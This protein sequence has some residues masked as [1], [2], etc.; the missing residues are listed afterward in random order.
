VSTPPR[1]LIAFQ[2]CLSVNIAAIGQCCHKHVDLNGFPGVSVYD[3]LL[4]LS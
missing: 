1:L 4:L 2:K 3:T